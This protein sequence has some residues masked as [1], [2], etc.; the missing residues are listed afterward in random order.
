MTAC[1]NKIILVGYLGKD[2]EQ[3]FTQSGR[4][5]TSFT[6]ATSET[7]K[8]D[9]GEREQRTEWFNVVAWNR[10]AEVCKTYLGK[11]S[12]VYLEGRLQSR[13]YE[14]ESG[15]Q[16]TLEVVASVVKMLDSAKN[17]NSTVSKKTEAALDNDEL[18][19]FEGDSA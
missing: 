5:V 2:P 7:W 19:I 11:G 3:R 14:T 8:I 16:R 1:V 9:D 13:S 12:R 18:P 17:E 15:K 4:P 6:L 10:L